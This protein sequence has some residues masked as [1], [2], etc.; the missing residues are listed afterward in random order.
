MDKDIEVLKEKVARACRML[1]MIGLIGYSGHIS[2]RIP[3]GQTFFIHP[4]RLSRTEVTPESMAEVTVQGEWVGG[5]MNPPSE[6]PIH[7]A[8][9]QVRNDVN[10]VVHIHPHYA[11]IPSMAGLDLVPMSQA[12]S[13]FGPVVP[14]YP[15]AEKI[16]DFKRAHDI[17]KSLGQSR[18]IILKGHGAVIVESTVE[19]ALGASVRLEQNA[20]FFVEACS[21]GKPIPLSEEERIRAFNAFMVSGFQKAWDYYIEKGRK[22]GIFWD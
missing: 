21:L 15:D 9:Y 16:S 8:V 3:G 10:S 20:R 2:G 11:L 1:E 18:A 4:Q 12:G 5:K 7:A 22:A 14:V 6:S 13:M 19:G 17:A